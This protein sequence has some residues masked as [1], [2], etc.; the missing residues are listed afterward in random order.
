MIHSIY[1]G[2]VEKVPQGF[3][4][5]AS[6]ESSSMSFTHFVTTFWQDITGWLAL[7]G[8]LLTVGTLLA[9]MHLK[10]EP[11]SAIAWSLTVLLMPFF[12]AL[13]FWVFGYQTVHRRLIRRRTRGRAYKQFTKRGDAVPVVVPH[14]W[15]VLARLGDRGDGFPVTGGNAVAFYHE[16]GSAFDAMLAAIERAEHHVHMQSFIV[17][18][19]ELGRRV[20]DAL[21]ACARRKVEVRLLVDSVGSYNLP[22]QLLRELT[23]RRPDRVVSATL[24]SAAA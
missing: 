6:N 22:S 17:H 15:D 9:V 20:I 19:D 7:L 10:R 18:S 14:R 21:C 4:P 12:G 23:R 8:V 2:A 5:V 13:F 11:M 3:R 1:P 16:G 24:Q